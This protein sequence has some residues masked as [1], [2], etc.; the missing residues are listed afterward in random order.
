MG[1]SEHGH[2]I[3]VPRPELLHPVR[4]G[5]ESRATAIPFFSQTGCTDSWHLVR[6][7]VAATIEAVR[8]AG[9]IGGKGR[10]ADALPRAGG[11]HRERIDQRQLRIRRPAVVSRA[12]DRNV[13][14]ASRGGLYDVRTPRSVPVPPVRAEC[15]PKVREHFVREP[16]GRECLASYIFELHPVAVHGPRPGTDVVVISAA[17]KIHGVFA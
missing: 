6:R 15:A 2:R 7:R 16:D 10:R 5:P 8:R 14:H 4:G 11:A 17:S 9:P 13:D 1:N 12:Q 3:L